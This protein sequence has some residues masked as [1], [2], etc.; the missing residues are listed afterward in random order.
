MTVQQHFNPYDKLNGI[1]EEDREPIAFSTNVG[2]FSVTARSREEL[3]EKTEM[4]KKYFGRWAFQHDP[5]AINMG[6]KLRAMPNAEI[7]DYQTMEAL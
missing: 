6:L 3:K 1:K 2:S 4:V 5:E 7:D